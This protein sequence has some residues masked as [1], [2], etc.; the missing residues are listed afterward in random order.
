MNKKILALTLSTASAVVFADVT[1]YGKLAV[2]IENDQFP[3]SS[4]SNANSVQDYGSY[5]GIRG[6]DPV[7]G[8]TAAIWQVETFLDIVSGQAYYNSSNGGL[9]LRNPNAGLPGGRRTH[10][11]LHC[12]AVPD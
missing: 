1:L 11:A 8:E 9:M 3:N 10:P 12:P 7:Y 2:G 6:S 4:L 5:F